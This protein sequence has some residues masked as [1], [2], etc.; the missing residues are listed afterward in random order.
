MRKVLLLERSEAGVFVWVS[1]GE[2]VEGMAGR[3]ALGERSRGEFSGWAIGTA[4]C[5]SV[6]QRWVLRGALAGRVCAFVPDREDAGC[7]RLMAVTETAAENMSVRLLP[8]APTS[9]CHCDYGTCGYS[10]EERTM[11]QREQRAVMITWKA[12]ALHSTALHHA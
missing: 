6:N 1:T 5:V 10:E 3:W 4:A 7:L 12:T 8:D 2:G 11:Q 9:H